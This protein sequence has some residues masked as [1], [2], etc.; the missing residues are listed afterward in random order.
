MRLQKLDDYQRSLKQ[1][2]N[3]PLDEYLRDDNVQAIVE[4]KLQLSIQVC[5][6]IANYLIAHLGLRPPDDLSGVFDVLGQEGIISHEL[7][8]KMTGMAS[9]RNILVHD[10]LKINPRIV[11]SHLTTRLGDFNDFAQA[12]ITEFGLDRL[13]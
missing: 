8:K 6:D 7:A 2:Q 9:F 5:L 1:F 3:I 11:H 13:E 12:I 10:Y 4:R